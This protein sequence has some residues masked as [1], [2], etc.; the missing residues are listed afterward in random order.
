MS[1]V[2]Q[3]TLFPYKNELEGFEKTQVNIQLMHQLAKNAGAISEAEFQN[4]LKKHQL[5]LETGG[6]VYAWK[7]LLSDTITRLTMAIPK[8]F[9]NGLEGRFFHLLYGNLSKMN[10]ENINLSSACLIGLYAPEHS[11]VGTQLRNACITDA[12]L[13]GC[14]F[15][16]CN[17]EGTVF[18]RSDLSGAIFSQA[19]LKQAN[20]E[21]CILDRATFKNCKTN[22]AIFTN[23]SLKNIQY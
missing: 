9:I 22:L 17:L 7:Q 13:N 19:N 16:G 23:A 5:F 14:D 12:S 2:N 6:E 18:S 20:F 21:N 8:K 1:L 10:L 15:S 4:L 11:F 3:Q